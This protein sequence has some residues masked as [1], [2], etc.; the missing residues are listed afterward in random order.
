MNFKNYLKNYKSTEL[1]EAL[2]TFGKKRPKFGQ[3]ILLAGGAGSGKGFVTD[4]LIGV[5]AKV[6][7]V[8]QVKSQIIHPATFKL[9]QKIQAKYGIDVS[10]LD[11]S[12]PE[13][14]KLLHKINDELG[15]SKK[16]QDQFLNSQRNK[17]R[18]PNIIFDTTMKSEKKL[19]N[20]VESVEL[21]GYKN[22]NIHIVWVVNDVNKAIQQNLAR[23]RVV[24]EDILIQTHQLVSETMASLLKGDLSKY[25]GGDVWV[26]F[27]KQFAD[28]TL[29]FASKRFEKSAT[30]TWATAKGWTRK[31]LGV[32]K[33]KAHKSGSYVKDVI[34]FKAKEQGKRQIPY[35][36]IGDLYM[37]RI[38]AYIPKDTIKVW[39]SLEEKLRES[40]DS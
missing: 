18:L 15:I 34:M 36:Q 25:I 4:T 26:V 1:N 2:I 10:K 38:K 17:D 8:D 27:N 22:E 33:A 20:I 24:P 40:L 31:E 9:N 32:I 3:V 13:D 28:S 37:K 21:G 30:T 35:S 6:M 16:L 11:L 39:E 5:Q 7:D 19:K 23:P 12:N 14:V 29:E